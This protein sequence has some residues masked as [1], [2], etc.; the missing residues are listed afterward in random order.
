MGPV[1]GNNA[2]LEVSPTSCSP[3]DVT[4]A[5]D[6]DVDRFV[7]FCSA[8]LSLRH[9]LGG[10][11]PVRRN[12]HVWWAYHQGIRLQLL[13]RRCD[14]GDSDSRQTILMQ[15]PTGVIGIIILLSSIFLVNRIKIRFIIICCLTL[16]AIGGAIGLIYVPRDNIGG[17]MGCYYTLYFYPALRAL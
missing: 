12:R 15:I 16:P 5:Q 3:S 11:V 9:V 7:T 1:L 2:G 17:L 4:Y 6:V 14:A 13:R 8:S 10:V